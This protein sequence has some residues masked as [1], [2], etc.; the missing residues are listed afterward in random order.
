[1]TAK[2]QDYSGGQQNKVFL[3]K[4][5]CPKYHTSN[6]PLRPGSTKQDAEIAMQ[7]PINQIDHRQPKLF[8]CVVT[9][10][11]MRAD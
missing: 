2:F 1:M 10:T 9:E 3:G 6:N 7:D 5:K 4:G 11:S 8:S